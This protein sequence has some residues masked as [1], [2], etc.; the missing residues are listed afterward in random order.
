MSA[1]Q[2]RK[3]ASGERE[4]AELLRKITGLDVQRRVRQHGGDSDLLGVNGWAIEVKRRRI[5]TRSDLRNWWA[6]TVDQ[7]GFLLPALLYRADRVD[8]RVV[9]PI[10]V[11]Q[12]LQHADQWHDYSWTSET[13]PECWWRI[14]GGGDG[15]EGD[16]G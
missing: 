7:A 15:T 8:W 12:T 4:A 2:R 6:Q 11:T 3:G 9:W 13:S 16:S 10:V 1:M 5:V 14:V